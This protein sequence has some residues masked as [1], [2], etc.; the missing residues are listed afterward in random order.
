MSVLILDNKRILL[1][2]ISRYEVDF[3]ELYYRNDKEEER[4]LFIWLINQDELWSEYSFEYL[5]I[6]MFDGKSYKF[7]SDK[8][9]YNLMEDMAYSF[10]ENGIYLDEEIPEEEHLRKAVESYV[11]IKDTFIFVDE[12]ISY[13][14]NRIDNAFGS[15]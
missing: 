10:E 6:K 3:E 5:Y 1:N 14:A 4:F 2:G 8:I 13:I 12:N 9:L 7:F 11:S 15:I